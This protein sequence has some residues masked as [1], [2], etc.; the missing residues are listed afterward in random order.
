MAG[1]G[2]HLTELATEDAVEAQSK[3]ALHLYAW[4]GA[5]GTFVWAV[6]TLILRL[7]PSAWVD[8]PAWTLLI[9]GRAS[10]ELRAIVLSGFGAAPVG[11]ALEAALAA[12]PQWVAGH[13]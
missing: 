3:G 10:Q 7:L 6:S 1:S 12:V 11:P 9:R 4:F 5:R 13:A 8:R 2:R